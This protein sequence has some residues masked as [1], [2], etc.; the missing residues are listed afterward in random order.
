MRLTTWGVLAMLLVGCGGDSSGPAPIQ[1]EGAWSGPVTFS[2][3]SSGTLSFTVTETAGSVTG[4]G[5][6][7]GSTSAALSVSGSYSEPNVSLTL[8]SP[9]FQPINLTGVV[10]SSSLTGTINGSGFLNSAV[11]LARQ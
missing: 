3:G 9:G 6:L 5:T 11:T 2:S 10:S 1:V 8:S 7:V 4:S